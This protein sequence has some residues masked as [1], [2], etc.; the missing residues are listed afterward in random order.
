MKWFIL[1]VAAAFVAGCAGSVSKPTA[2][3]R[4]MSV[5][6]VTSQGI[7]LNF[8][9]DVENPNS[10]ALPLA[11]L[12]YDLTLAE[13]KVL[14]GKTKPEG[15]VPAQGKRGVVLPVTMTF[16]NLLAAEEGIRKSGGDVPLGLAAN[17]EFT[18]PGSFASLGNV[19]VPLRYSGT[20]KMREILKDPTIILRSPAAR[21]LAE[22]VFGSWL[23]R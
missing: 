16:E 12:D 3:V 2:S 9:V 19:S 10:F 6:E 20:L 11:E 5:K 15:S 7:T 23:G 14:D 1:C 8:D 17:L 4:S 13:V 18:P 21:R 22:K